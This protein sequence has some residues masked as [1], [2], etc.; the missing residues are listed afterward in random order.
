MY[1]DTHCHL[2]FKAFLGG[3][4][5]ILRKA[6][7]ADVSTIVVPGTDLATSEQAVAIAQANRE[8]YALVGIHPHHAS[9]Y[10]SR[11]EST[12]SEDLAKLAVWLD[13][14]KVVGIG[15]VGLDRHTYT[16]SRYGPSISI[17]DDVFRI[18]V[19]LFLRQ[20][21]LAVSRQTSLC[22]HNREAT[23][24]LIE[25]WASLGD[26]TV[27]RDR[28]VLHCCEPHS[29]LL[30]FA[31]QCGMYIGVD[32]DITYDKAKRDFISQVPLNRLVLETDSPYILP[33]PL[34]SLKKHPNVPGNI[35]L[36]AH[37][38]A[39]VKGVSLEQVQEVTTTNARTLFDLPEEEGADH[40]EDKSN[41][42]ITQ[43]VSEE[44]AQ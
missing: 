11:A 41:H 9:Q 39:E 20:V 23:R 6:V 12:I 37:V 8:V 28:A 10:Q 27:L 36:I 21:E 22:I 42:H 26:M 40:S 2:N 25:C 18:Q 16:Q 33:E 1:I 30:S 3:E 29:D 5:T 32:G 17:D 31:E 43:E 4:R 13:Q 15:E 19:E 14:E 38:V 44:S 24:D 7:S 34:R 35:P